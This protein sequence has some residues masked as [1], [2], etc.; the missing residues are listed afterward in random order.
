VRYAVYADR[1]GWSPSQVDEIPLLTDAWL[2][3][4]ANA[5]GAEKAVRE[6]KARKKK[7]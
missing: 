2:L 3:P 4:I 6:E 7:A 1:F 5:I